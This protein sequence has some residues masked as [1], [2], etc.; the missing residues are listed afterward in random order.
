MLEAAPETVADVQSGLSALP[1]SALGNQGYILDLLP[2]LQK[3]YTESDNGTLIA[4]ICMNFLT[5]QPGQ[6][7]FV[8]AD[9]LHAY[10]S[11]DIIECMAR[12]NNMLNT[13]F[14]PPA[15]RDDINLFT[16]AL[17]FNPQRAEEALLVAKVSERG[18]QGRTKVFEPPMSEFDMLVTR[19]AA[20]QRETVD[21]LQGPSVMVVTS[22]AGRM[23]AE[24]RTEELDEGS[25]YFVGQGVELGLETDKEDGLVVYRAFAE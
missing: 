12:S 9:G 2:R 4:L 20:G 25:V 21:A 7:I 6:A 19:L 16:E 3:Q 13:G 14:C 5:L 11:G 10:L 24:G 8:P 23:M 18:R 15:D 1:C 22:G 17:T